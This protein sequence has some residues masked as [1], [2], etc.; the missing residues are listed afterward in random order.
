MGVALKDILEY[1]TIELSSIS[2]KK[3]AIDSF[4]MIYQFLASIRQADGTSLTDS[5]GNVTSHLKG[6][7]NRCVY[8]KK[9]NIK[10][11]FVFDGE[12]PNLK[13]AERAIRAKK[14]EDAKVKYQEALDNDDLV[15]AKKHAQALNKLTPIMVKDSI[16]LIEAFGFPVVLAPS[17][18]EAQAG[19]L[20]NEGKVFAA[21]SQDF[22][23]LLFGTKYLIRNLSISNKRKIPGSSIYRDVPIEFYD[24]DKVLEHLQITLD[25]LIIVAI[26]CGTDFNPGGI[27]GI[28]PKKALKMVRDYKDRWDEIFTTLKWHDYFD[29]TW[30]E[31]FNVFKHMKTV[32]VDVEFDTISK[33]SIREILQAHDFELSMIDRSLDGIKNVRTLDSFF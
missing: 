3:I 27:K 12:A 32:D 30:I 17:E 25:E 21:C 31:V 9:N 11:V 16:S 5:K 24:L 13:E 33:D 2:N 19:R 20:C 8:F 1:D 10:A 7:F 14:K 22:D 15:E 28:G 23:S 4:N 29:H 6:L 18:G 26:L